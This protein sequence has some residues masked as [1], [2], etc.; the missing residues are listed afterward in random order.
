L[1]RAILSILA[2]LAARNILSAEDFTSAPSQIARFVAID[3]ICAWPALV[4]LP[5]GEVVAIMHNRPSHG[6]IEGEIECWGSS[7]GTAGNFPKI[8]T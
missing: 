7:D 1:N 2:G 5:G 8:G 6:Q 3:N 4:S